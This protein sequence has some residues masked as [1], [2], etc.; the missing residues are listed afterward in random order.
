MMKISVLVLEMRMRSFRRDRNLTPPFHVEGAPPCI[1]SEAV[2]K[3]SEID[4]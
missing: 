1:P 3:F 4:I 2:Y